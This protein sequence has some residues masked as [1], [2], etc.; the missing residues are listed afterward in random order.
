MR[1]LI[2]LVMSWF[3]SKRIP[4][5]FL[6]FFF[7]TLAIAQSNQSNWKLVWSD[8]FNEKGYLDTT[9]WSKIPR[10]AVHWKRYMSDYDSC[11]AVKEGNLV[12]RGILNETLKNDT[13]PYITGGVCTKGRNLFFFFL[14]L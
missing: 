11:Y 14:K 3:M 1:I 5:I 12:L 2:F 8:E 10:G 7:F 13:A 9:I 6:S 4:L